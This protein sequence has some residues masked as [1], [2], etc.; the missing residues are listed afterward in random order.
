VAVIVMSSKA[1]AE[2]VHKAALKIKN[3]TEWGELFYKHSQTAPKTRGANSPLDLAG[4]LGV[5]GPLDDE[6]GGNPKVPEAVRGAVFRI[7]NVGSVADELIQDGGKFYIVRM[8]GI[9]AAHHRTL[10]E[11][12]RTIRIAL[13]QEKMQ[14]LE[15]ELEEELRKKFPVEIDERALAAVKLP[16]ALEK[17]DVA[18]AAS[19][20]SYAEAAAWAAADA[21]ADGSAGAGEPG[22]A[23]AAEGGGAPQALGLDGGP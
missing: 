16:P 18:S 2:K 14:K 13:M 1:E 19:P 9:T 21:G 4:D 6:K 17:M 10:A 20:Q 15:R 5:V 23:G 7:A 11:A 22:G 8:N 12:D 3:A